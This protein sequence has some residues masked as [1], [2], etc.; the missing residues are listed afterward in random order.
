EDVIGTLG[1][2]E[3][4]IV[5]VFSDT[6]SR[7]AVFQLTDVTKARAATPCALEATQHQAIVFS[8]PGKESRREWSV[9]ERSRH[10]AVDA[11][12]TQIHFQ[13]NL[14]RENQELASDIRAGEI[15]TSIGLGEAQPVSFSHQRAEGN[16][17][18]EG[19]KQ[20]A[21]CSRKDAF[22]LRHDVSARDQ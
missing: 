14:S 11:D 19:V 18:V 10:Q 3:R 5:C 13:S 2:R 12:I 8:I 16:R 22:D 20:I 4:M 15:V 7:A 6:S 9:G 17:T 1:R 21:Q